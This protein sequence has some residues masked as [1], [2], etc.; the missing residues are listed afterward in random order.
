MVFAGGLTRPTGTS[1]RNHP[2]DPTASKPVVPV[3]V[4]RRW[5]R[6]GLA[7][8]QLRYLPGLPSRR[9]VPPVK[10]LL[11]IVCIVALASASGAAAKVAPRGLLLEDAKKASNAAVVQ[12]AFNGSPGTPSSRC[13]KASWMAARC[14]WSVTVTAETG[15]RFSKCSGTLSIVRRQ[16]SGY[17]ITATRVAGTR[18]TCVATA[19]PI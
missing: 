17:P 6:A 19:S 2:R 16:V 18:V 3:G 13:K 9:I 11:P 4:V 7:V 5:Y 8:R 14:T 10:R 1:T 12:M 15:D